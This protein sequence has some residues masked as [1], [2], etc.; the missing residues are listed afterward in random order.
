LVVLFK[1][2]DW[3]DRL[4]ALQLLEQR[5]REALDGKPTRIDSNWA[6]LGLTPIAPKPFLISQPVPCPCPARAL[7]SRRGSAGV[8]T[9]IIAWLT[10]SE[11]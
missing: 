4:E 1:L 11:I 6:S 9:S 8:E 5:A 3:A 10:V 7:Q 2:V